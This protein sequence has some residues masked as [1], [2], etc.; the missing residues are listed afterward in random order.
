MSVNNFDDSDRP[1]VEPSRHDMFALAETL[2][3]ES[4]FLIEIAKLGRRRRLGDDNAKQIVEASPV[5]GDDGAQ[6]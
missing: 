4:S 5:H 3:K 2:A 1:Y 6:S